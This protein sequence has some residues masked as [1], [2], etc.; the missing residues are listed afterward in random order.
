LQENPK[1]KKAGAA[2]GRRGRLSRLRA[3]GDIAAR[4]RV[5]AHEYL[6]A[7]ARLRLVKPIKPPTW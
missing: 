1:V 4:W 3:V 7:P 5:S 6:S 2:G